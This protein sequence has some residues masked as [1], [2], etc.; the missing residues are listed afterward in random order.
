MIAWQSQ[1][2]CLRRSQSCQLWRRGRIRSRG[3][4][5]LRLYWLYLSVVTRASRV[6][7]PSHISRGTRPRGA[8]RHGADRSLLGELAQ[9]FTPGAARV[10]RGRAGADR[11]CG[12]PD[13]H[14]RCSLETHA[15]HDA[16]ANPLEQRQ[17]RGHAALCRTIRGS[18]TR[19]SGRLALSRTIHPGSSVDGTVCPATASCSV[20]HARVP[21]S[22]V[23]RVQ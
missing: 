8:R 20:K 19:S 3:L 23:Q 17:D 22:N 4:V 9:C 16:G 12:R 5:G 13:C 2:L 10:H 14:R 7:R 18:G 11:R 6:G 15:F 1:Q 21:G